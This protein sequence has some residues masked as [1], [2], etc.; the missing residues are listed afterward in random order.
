MCL[1][2]FEGWLVHQIGWSADWMVND[3]DWL[4]AVGMHSDFERFEVKANQDSEQTVFGFL[5]FYPSFEVE[6]GFRLEP[7]ASYFQLRQILY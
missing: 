6:F 1:A 4:A 7:Q 2:V 5:F 3:V